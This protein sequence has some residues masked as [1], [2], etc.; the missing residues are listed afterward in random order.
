MPAMRAEDNIPIGQM[1]A[2]TGSDRFLTD[3]GVTGAVNE[4]SLMTTS[5][6][7]F[8]LPN[9]LHGSIELQNR[10]FFHE[11]LRLFHHDEVSIA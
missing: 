3:I 7:L 10:L 1:S 9:Q 2:H 6:L 4:S 11:S 5:Q 8:R